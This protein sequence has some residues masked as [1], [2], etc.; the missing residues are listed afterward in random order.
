MPSKD[1]L[2]ASKFYEEAIQEIMQLHHDQLGYKRVEKSK[3]NRQDQWGCLSKRWRQI[4]ATIHFSDEKFVL[5]E[6]KHYKTKVSVKTVEAFDATVRLD[7][8][9]DGKKK[10]G[11]MVVTCV[12]FSKP[13][14]NYAKARDI[15]LVTLNASATKDQYVM[16]M[17]GQHM[18]VFLT[19]VGFSDALEITDTFSHSG[20]AKFVDSLVLSDE[21]SKLEQ[22]PG[23]FGLPE[24]HLLHESVN[25]DFKPGR[26]CNNY[27][28][29]EPEVGQHELRL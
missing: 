27:P 9:N 28:G 14:I 3:K 6:C 11:A 12:G 13:A 15:G 21:G 8:G 17:D 1:R 7:V 2:K 16:K 18:G 10:I 24:I 4:D 20:E 29:G 19:F 25:A 23:L 26:F 22:T 5:V